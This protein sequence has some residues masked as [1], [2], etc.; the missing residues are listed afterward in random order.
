MYVLVAFSVQ[1]SRDKTY[2][3][4]K[5]G[6]MIKQSLKCKIGYKGLKCIALFFLRDNFCKWNYKVF[7]EYDAYGCEEC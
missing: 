1:V 3:K 6:L 7:F 5:K 4:K 2:K